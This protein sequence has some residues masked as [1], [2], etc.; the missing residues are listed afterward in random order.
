MNKKTIGLISIIVSIVII[1]SIVSVLSISNVLSEES[2]EIDFSI[3][4]ETADLRVNMGISLSISYSGDDVNISWEIGSAQYFG[5]RISI[6]FSESNF[7]QVNVSLTG[8]NKHG[9]TTTHLNVKNIDL[10]DGVQ[11]GIPLKNIVGEYTGFQSNLEVIN[12]TTNPNATIDFEVRSGIGNIGFEVWLSNEKFLEVIKSESVTLT[13]N[14]HTFEYN[15]DLNEY[16]TF[17]KPYNVIINLFVYKG[18]ISGF[19]FEFEI[20][21]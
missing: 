20:N 10:H 16:N 3:I 4:Q 19:N 9:F 18:A 17:E 12:G 1:A 13:S 21:Y 11:N 14:G 6:S 2:E 5:E 15:I 7:Y 8:D